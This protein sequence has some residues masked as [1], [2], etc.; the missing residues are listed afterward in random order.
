[1]I[2]SIEYR[3]SKYSKI[4]SKI[5]KIDDE[6]LSLSPNVL[7]GTTVEFSNPLYKE[8]I[9]WKFTNGKNKKMEKNFLF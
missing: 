2:P 4:S 7:S 9:N 6:T 5:L 3:S 8:K 1:M